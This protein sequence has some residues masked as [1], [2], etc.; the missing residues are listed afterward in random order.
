MLKT[1]L[2]LFFLILAAPV[3][4]ALTPEAAAQLRVYEDSL[5]TTADSMYYAPIPDTRAGYALQFVRQLK[6]ALAIPGSYEY[7]FDSLGQTISILSPDD[8]AFRI[9]NWAIPTGEVTRRYYGAIQRPGDA[10]R[11]SGLVDVSPLLGKGAEDTVLSGG[12]WFGALY[13]RIH[14]ATWNDEKIY[15]LFGLNNAAPATNRKV[16]DVLRLTPEGPQFGAPVFGIR[17]RQTK[18]RVRRFILEYRRDVQ[19][20]LN[21]NPDLGAIYFDRLAPEGGDEGRKY[22]YVPTGEVDGFR[23]TGEEWKFVRDL[24]PITILRDGEPVIGGRD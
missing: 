20:S 16:L 1:L 9:F 4:A 17:S 14:T 6:G 19:A 24:I 23:W 18:D 12:R 15:T 13:Y 10:L 22:T 11:L 3:H 21:W 5:R 2:P 7:P 8:R